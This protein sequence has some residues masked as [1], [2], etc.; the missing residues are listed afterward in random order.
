MVGADIFVTVGSEE[1]VQHLMQKYGLPRNRILHSRDSSFVQGIMAQTDHQGVD[2]IL[3]SVSGE[4]L[5]DTWKCVAP[6]GKLVEIGKR[7]LIGH[8][9]LDMQPF[10][11]NR[12]YCCVDISKFRQTPA[13]LTRYVLS[14]PTTLYGTDVYIVCYAGYRNTTKKG[15]SLRSVP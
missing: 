12:S 11:A 14:D 13:M 1:K 4:L 5:H 10:L 7:D 15:Q 9:K 6:F 8:G 3:N 2:L